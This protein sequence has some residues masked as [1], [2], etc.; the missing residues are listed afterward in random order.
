VAGL[1]G[2]TSIWLGNDV[3]NYTAHIIG[4]SIAYRFK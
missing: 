3:K 4:A 1:P 2:Q